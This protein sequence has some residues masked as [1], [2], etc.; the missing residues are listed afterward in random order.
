[1]M[2]HIN[3]GVLPPTGPP[4]IALHLV[5]QVLGGK[6]TPQ[7]TRL[8]SPDTPAY[9]LQPDVGH[10]G[11]EGGGFLLSKIEEK[12]PKQVLNVLKYTLIM[13]KKTRTLH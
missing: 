13:L 4:I 12:L 9:P 1:M 8:S 2:E 3:E 5:V 7:H 11:K 10:R 6:Q